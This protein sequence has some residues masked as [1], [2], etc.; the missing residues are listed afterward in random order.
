[1]EGHTLLCFEATQLLTLKRCHP[2]QRL[3]VVMVCGLWH[4]CNGCRARGYSPRWPLGTC[5]GHPGYH[6][7]RCPRGSLQGVQSTRDTL[8]H[9]PQKR[10]W[11][12][13][14][15]GRA[16]KSMMPPTKIAPGLRYGP[17]DRRAP[18]GRQGARGYSR[19]VTHLA[20]IHR[21]VKPQ[22]GWMV[23]ANPYHR[24]DP[25]RYIRMHV[26]R[27]DNILI[28]LQDHLRT[29]VLRETLY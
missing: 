28:P 14:L 2:V 15:P 17:T 6:P 13:P 8:E 5:P 9:Q 10:G 27:N 24:F 7:L 20:C 23:V 1:M 18:A 26:S 4:R 12:C 25:R 19:M 16:T 11:T 29:S 3:P 22:D 21:P